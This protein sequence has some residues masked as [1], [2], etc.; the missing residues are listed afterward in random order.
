MNW[1]YN[2]LLLFHTHSI[3]EYFSSVKKIFLVLPY[4]CCFNKKNIL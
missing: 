1:H 4:F 2:H 3:L